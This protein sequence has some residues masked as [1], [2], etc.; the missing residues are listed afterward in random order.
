MRR[1]CP[2]LVWSFAYRAFKTWIINFS[3]CSRVSHGSNFF[4]YCQI[5]KILI[6][7]SI[8]PLHLLLLTKPE[9]TSSLLSSL[10][11]TF[12]PIFSNLRFY[13][14]IM[15][16][17]GNKKVSYKKSPLDSSIFSVSKNKRYAQPVKPVMPT[18]KSVETGF[19][20]LNPDTSDQIQ[21]HFGLY[22]CKY[23]G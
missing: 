16:A 1:I 14:L 4:H 12:F 6:S 13:Y 23:F 7:T 22:S 18:E 10:L 9:Q 19:E 8:P 21:Q 5:L 3:K 11:P 15:S 20:V 17:L 2:E